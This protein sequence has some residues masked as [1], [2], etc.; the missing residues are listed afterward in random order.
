MASRILRR[1]MLVLKIDSRGD[2]PANLILKIFKPVGVPERRD[3][4][5]SRR[6]RDGIRL[7]RRV[8]RFG[9]RSDGKY[10][11]RDVHSAIRAAGDS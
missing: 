11:R 9:M 4:K 7:L 5:G 10:Q 3:R 1:V 2:E 8:Q 6:V